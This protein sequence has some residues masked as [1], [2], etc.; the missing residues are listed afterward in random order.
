VDE[1]L[2]EAFGVESGNHRAQMP[3][4]GVQDIGR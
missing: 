1:D 2:G 4:L 3:V